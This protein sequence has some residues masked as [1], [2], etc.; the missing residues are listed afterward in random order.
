MH[1]L[2]TRI[3]SQTAFIDSLVPAEILQSAQQYVQVPLSAC[4]GS[5]RL[6]SVNVVLTVDHLFTTQFSVQVLVHF[7]TCVVSCV[8]TQCRDYPLQCL[9]PGV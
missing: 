6:T 2:Q 5:Q 8:H 9:T 1:Q 7:S 4:S 3:S